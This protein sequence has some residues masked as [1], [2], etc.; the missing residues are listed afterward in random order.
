ML[1]RVSD[2]HSS[3]GRTEAELPVETNSQVYLK[4]DRTRTEEFYE[5]VFAGVRICSDVISFG[6][7]TLVCFAW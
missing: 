5:L 1:H 6:N 3:F 2:F 7:V 4:P